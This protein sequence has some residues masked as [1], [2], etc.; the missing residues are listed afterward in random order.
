MA[1]VPSKSAVNR[2]VPPGMRVIYTEPS[3]AMTVRGPLVTVACT[4]SVVLDVARSQRFYESMKHLRE[5]SHASLL[6]YAYVMDEKV[7]MPDAPARPIGAKVMALFDH[8]VGIHEG[9]GW[10]ASA[11]RA[12]LTS[13]A[14]LSRVSLRGRIE[15]VPDVETAAHRM[16]PHAQGELTED[17]IREAIAVTRGLSVS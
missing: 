2:Q 17:A 4:G 12:V 6:L 13:V 10:R 3:I 1:V 15:V 11:V 8:C 16:A 14:M 5:T 9:E 7:G